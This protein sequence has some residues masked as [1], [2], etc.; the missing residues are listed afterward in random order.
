MFK[1]KKHQTTNAVL[2]NRF[3]PLNA[4]GWSGREK[5][6]LCE[7]EKEA[8]E[9]WLLFLRKKVV[10]GESSVTERGRGGRVL[11]R[12]RKPYLCESTL[13]N[14]VRG[15]PQAEQKQPLHLPLAACF[16]P[17]WSQFNQKFKAPPRLKSKCHIYESSP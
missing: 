9:E 5:M 6:G 7:P 10:T 2:A 16:P 14:T 17:A 13:T 15:R 4:G 11:F 1:K 12:K 3:P 8:L